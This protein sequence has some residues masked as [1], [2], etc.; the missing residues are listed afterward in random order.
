MN[1]IF[2][3][4]DLGSNAVKLKIAQV[5]SG[6][7]TALEDISVP[8]PLG[9]EVFSRHAVSLE[10]ISQLITTL[11]YFKQ[12]MDTYGVFMSR[13]VATAALREAENGK[14][15]IEIIRMK[16]GI[17]VEIIEDTIEKFLTYKSI[18]DHIPSY[19]DIRRSALLIEINSGSSD[20]S[21]YAQNKLIRN[22]EL[23]LGIKQLKYLLMDLET[24]TTDYPYVLKELIEAQTAHLTDVVSGR[25]LNTVLALG[26]KAKRIRTVLFDDAQAIPLKAFK[27]VCARAFSGDALIR[28]TVES[29]RNNWYEILATLAVYD[30]FTDAVTCSDIVIPDIS[31]RDGILAEAIEQVYG[32]KRYRAFNN[33]IFTLAYA[34]SKRYKSDYRH[35]RWV[36]ESALRIFEA[37]KTQYA[38][39][40]RDVILLRLAAILHEIGKFTRTKD[41]LD[42]TYEKILTLEVFGVTNAEM[43]MVAHICRLIS[44]SGE[45]AFSPSLENVQ[46]DDD[47]RIFK[48]SAIL[49]ISDALD[50]S[51]KQCIDLKNVVVGD[52]ACFIE[53]SRTRETVLEDW[54]FEF[55]VSNFANTF[56]IVP[57]LKDVD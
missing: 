5:Y 56:G 54:S 20:I 41:Y 46:G 50:K 36:E 53:V 52:R 25:R 45:P 39:H 24:R 8:T 30:V 14:S 51:K 27:A 9:E 23:R 38:F 4:I 33:D 55:V 43:V 31:L 42:A 18:R 28:D 57:E 32:V 12:T 6:E 48:L 29:S 37:L 17:D 10:T 34:I 2:A 15:I 21:V 26:G 22:D 7:I 44:S 3:A 16:V 19:Q 49:S 13:A 40:P 47:V 11:A 1:T 35:I